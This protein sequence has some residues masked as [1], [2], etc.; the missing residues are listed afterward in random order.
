MSPGIESG[1]FAI[2]GAVVGALGAALTGIIQSVMNSRARR[3][4]L[5]AE[6]AAAVAATRR[7][8]YEQLIAATYLARTAFLGWR[9]TPVREQPIRSWN[10]DT[11]ALTDRIEEAVRP[12]R[13]DGS[14]RANQLAAQLLANWEAWKDLPEADRFTAETLTAMIEKLDQAEDDLTMV[15]RQETGT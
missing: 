5:K 1:L 14:A 3:A 9:R 10:F 12:V 15:A 4:E 7:P 13:I 8:L 11:D 2:I 6:A